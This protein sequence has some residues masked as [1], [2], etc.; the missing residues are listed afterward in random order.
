MTNLRSINLNISARGL[1]ALESVDPKLGQLLL[2]ESIEMPS[3]LIHFV[4]GRTEA[5]LYDPLRGNCSNSISRSVLNQRLIEA[6]PETIDT[7]FNTKLTRV[8]FHSQTAYG[9]ATSRGHGLGEEG[10][11]SETSTPNRSAEV[12]SQFDLI[13]GADGSWSRV[14]EQM[15]RH[16]RWVA[17]PEMALLTPQR[18]LCPDVYPSRIH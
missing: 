9:I 3:R 18:R 17:E 11:V 2:D 10:D 16:Q 4:D 7:K 15:M 14:R 12:V 5:Q 1:G 13:V 6:L 8:D